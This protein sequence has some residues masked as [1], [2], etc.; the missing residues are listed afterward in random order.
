M[1]QG[2]LSDGTA[3]L[4]R[5]HLKSYMI[6]IELRENPYSTSSHVSIH[7]MFCFSKECLRNQ[8]QKAKFEQKPLNFKK[9]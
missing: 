9:K 4:K 1:I 7:V 6:L 3:H 8:L 5:N 2:G